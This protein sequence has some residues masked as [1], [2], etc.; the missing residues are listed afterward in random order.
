MRAW[1]APRGRE[2]NGL[3][4]EAWGAPRRWLHGD[5]NGELAVVEL[6]GEGKTELIW[7][8]GRGVLGTQHDAV[9]LVGGLPE[10]QINAKMSWPDLKKMTGGVACSGQTVES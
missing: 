3:L 9:D 4:G 2:G 7:G 8:M 10:K 5:R 6:L 1:A